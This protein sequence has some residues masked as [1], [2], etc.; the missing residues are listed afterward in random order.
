MKPIASPTLVTLE[1]EC[2]GK[3][4][5]ALSE[6]LLNPNRMMVEG[7]TI[8]AVT[9]RGKIYG[10]DADLIEQAEDSADWKWRVYVGLGPRI[11]QLGQP[12]VYVDRLTNRAHIPQ[13]VHGREFLDA[14]KST[15]HGALPP[16]GYSL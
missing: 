1:I 4:Y 8:G 5:T 2:T 15:G 7:I 14:L 6:A 9:I 12:D 16:G 3:D 10:L 11:Q 13:E